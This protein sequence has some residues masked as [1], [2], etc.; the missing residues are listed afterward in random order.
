MIQQH[1]VYKS[2]ASYATPQVEQNKR[3]EKIYQLNIN[4][5]GR[6]DYINDILKKILQTTGN[7]A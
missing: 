5:K 4:Q 3:R 1:A 6:C 7:I 2:L